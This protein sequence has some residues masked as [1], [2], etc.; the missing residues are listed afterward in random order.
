MAI[1]IA[2]IQ[3]C[4]HVRMFEWYGWHYYYAPIALLAKLVS[5]DFVPLTKLPLD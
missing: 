4:P 1:S 2:S 3:I 5:I